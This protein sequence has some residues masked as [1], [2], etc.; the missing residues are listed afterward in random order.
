MT[1]IYRYINKHRAECVSCLI[2]AILG[3]WIA[4]YLAAIL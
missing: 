4:K 1:R 3:V 2:G